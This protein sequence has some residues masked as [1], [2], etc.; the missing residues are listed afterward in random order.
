MQGLQRG[1]FTVRIAAVMMA[2]LLGLCTAGAARGERLHFNCPAAAR[3]AVQA[4]VLK[5]FDVFLVAER[6]SGKTELSAVAFKLQLPDGLTMA[7]EELAVES[8]IGLGTTRDGINLVFRC[9]DKPQQQVMHFRFL[10]TRP[11]QG[12]LLTLGPEPRTNFLGVV[13]C[14]SET[15]AK[16]AT[17]PDTLRIDAR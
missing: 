1:R 15:F 17:P 3:G 16:F 14:R 12:A 10:A 2:V 5:P 6:D 11:L 8:I 4:G 9:T 13:A 7:G